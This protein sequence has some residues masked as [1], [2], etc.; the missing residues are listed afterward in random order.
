MIKWLL[1]RPGERISYQLLKLK[2]GISNFI[3][4]RFI[5]FLWRA[6]Y[7]IM[8]QIKNSFWLFSAKPS[9]FFFSKMCSRIIWEYGFP[10]EEK[11]SLSFEIGPYNLKLCPHVRCLLIQ[12]FKTLLHVVSNACMIKRIHP[13]VCATGG[14]STFNVSQQCKQ[15]PRPCRG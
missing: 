12:D 8:S 11:A 4:E 7:Y 2:F 1:F 13:Q 5:M 6:L 10:R 9:L 14:G 15:W 3:S